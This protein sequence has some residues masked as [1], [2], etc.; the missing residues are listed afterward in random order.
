MCWMLDSGER[1]LGHYNSVGS[2]PGPYEGWHSWSEAQLGET[3][4]GLKVEKDS[5]RYELEQVD[6]N[7]LW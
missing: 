3:V 4:G 6:W 2:E 5:V 1:K 7:G